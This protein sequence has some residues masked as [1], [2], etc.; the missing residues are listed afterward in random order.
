MLPGEHDGTE[1][2]SKRTG[3]RP[4]APAPLSSLTRDHARHFTVNLEVKLY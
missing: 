4:L 2:E 1:S 3:R